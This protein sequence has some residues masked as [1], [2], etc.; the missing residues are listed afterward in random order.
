[1]VANLLLLPILRAVALRR[2]QGRRIHVVQPGCRQLEGGRAFM[3]QGASLGGYGRL[4]CRH[5]NLWWCKQ[6]QSL[7]QA[8]ATLYHQLATTVNGHTE[9]SKVGFPRRPSCSTFAVLIS[10]LANCSLLAFLEPE[11]ELCPASLSLKFSSRKLPCA[12]EHLL[13]AWEPRCCWEPLLRPRSLVGETLRLAIFRDD[14]LLLGD[15]ESSLM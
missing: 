1:M 7:I 3:G 12:L 15:W 6:G 4:R 11:I 2:Q 8:L 14:D 5:G 9:L 10:E 13:S